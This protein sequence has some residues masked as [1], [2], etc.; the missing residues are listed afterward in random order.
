[1]AVPIDGVACCWAGA[2]ALGPPVGGVPGSDSSGPWVGCQC[3][4][5]SVYLPLL[6]D[7]KAI[8]VDSVN[9]L[10]LKRRSTKGMNLIRTRPA[11]VRA[12]RRTIGT[13][14]SGR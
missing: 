12:C 13:R 6:R 8:I 9:Y 2:P 11:Y 5:M 3:S 14:R 1:M 4:L 7:S 10:D